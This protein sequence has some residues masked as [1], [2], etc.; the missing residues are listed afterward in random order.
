[1]NYLIDSLTNYS[2]IHILLNHFPSVGTL[3]GLA[4]LVYGL[5]KKDQELQIVSLVIF[6]V[7]AVL[8]IPTFVTGGAAS[9]A[10]K[11]R[12]GLD[13]AMVDLHR[14][15]AIVAS[16]VLFLTG[17]FAWL[18]LWQYRR[19]QALS[20]WNVWSVAGLSVLTMALM[21]QAGTLGGEISH[22]EIRV[23]GAPE[24]VRAASAPDVTAPPVGQEGLA[25]ALEKWAN[26][27]L[28]AWP[29][30]ET[31]HFTGLSLLFGVMLLVNFR[32]L[33]VLK[34]VPF[35]AIHRFLPLGILGF[36]VTMISGLLMFNGVI[37]RYAPVGAF[38]V[39]MALVVVGSLSV[40]YVTTFKDTW[41]LGTGDRTAFRHKLFAVTTTLLWMAVLLIGRFLP[42]LGTGN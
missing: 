5:W 28:W 17:T 2:H 15:A 13:R 4:L 32:L 22:P 33:G 1:M 21:L 18:A 26:D 3:F 11:H 6:M 8:T 9:E 7:M 24:V 10:I 19:F 42:A 35:S 14:T 30:C 36:G 23:A 16:S 38:Y 41:T 31:V 39:K 12:P 25:L 27:E 37:S 34:M 29:L 40:L 20:R